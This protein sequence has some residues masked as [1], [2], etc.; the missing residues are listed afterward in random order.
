MIE[1]NLFE[2]EKKIK[3]LY[4]RNMQND[5]MKPY[6]TTP[7]KH[8]SSCKQIGGHPLFLDRM[9]K[10]QKNIASPEIIL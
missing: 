4:A 8:K 9:E 6:N 3:Y 5:M 7:E 1:K 10:L 2:I